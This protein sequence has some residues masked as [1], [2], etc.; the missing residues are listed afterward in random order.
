[1]D[2]LGGWALCGHHGGARPEQVLEPDRHVGGRG[3]ESG[4]S[5][6]GLGD[7]AGAFVEGADKQAAALVSVGKKGRALHAERVEG[8]LGKQGRVLLVRSGLK[9]V[10]EQVECDIRIDGG[11]A[12]S[13]EETLV[14]QPAPA[15]AVVGEGEVRRPGG[16]N[17]QFSRQ[18][19]CVCGKSA[20]CDGI[21]SFGHN[22]VE[23]SELLERIIEP[24][25]LVGNKFRQDVGGEDLCERAEPQERVLGRRL[26]GVGRGL[27]VPAEKDLI[28]ANDDQNHT[29]GAGLKEEI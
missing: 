10:A 26:V 12:G 20:E 3:V 8:A 18:A 5:S 15:S 21:V 1:M 6:G 16:R 2:G 22:C 29:R 27:A 19:G 13:A 23:W 14:R 28:V 9:R 25:G 24:Y 17:P 11:S 7:G 4:A